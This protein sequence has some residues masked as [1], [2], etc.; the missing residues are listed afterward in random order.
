MVGSMHV[1]EDICDRPL[2]IKSTQRWRD[3]KLNNNNKKR[4]L[5]TRSP[6]WT[7]A[8]KQNQGERREHE[9]RKGEREGE[10]RRKGEMRI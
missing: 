9:K 7:R 8:E 6:D 3:G 4:L 10:E 2:L 5:S 1:H